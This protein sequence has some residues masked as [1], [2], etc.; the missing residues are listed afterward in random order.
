MR[1]FLASH[2]ESLIQASMQELTAP[3][4]D[5]DG[6]PNNIELLAVEVLDL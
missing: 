2:Y 6:L 3:R 1:G 4:H 5:V